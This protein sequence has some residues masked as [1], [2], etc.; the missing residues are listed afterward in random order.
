MQFHDMR[1]IEKADKA[2]EWDSIENLN[3]EHLGVLAGWLI[4]TRGPG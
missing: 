4:G 3:F 1:R 2:F